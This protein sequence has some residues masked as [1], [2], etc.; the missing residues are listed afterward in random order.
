MPKALCPRRS[1][2][3]EDP[4]IPRRSRPFPRG[5]RSRAFPGETHGEERGLET[6]FVFQTFV[7]LNGPLSLFFRFQLW[8]V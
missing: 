2:R 8:I 3:R 7:W 4:A 5:R 1:G 6:T